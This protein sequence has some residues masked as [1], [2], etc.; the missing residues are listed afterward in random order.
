MAVTPQRMTLA[1]FLELPEVKPALELR[2][3]VVSQK[4]PPSG[5]HSSIQMWFGAQVYNYGEL[6]GLAQAFTEARVI[7]NGDAYVPDVIVFV[8]DR[9][10]VDESGRYPFYFTLPPDL[11]LE[12]VSPGQT[13]SSQLDKCL[14]L[15]EHGVRV[16]LL[17]DPE[18]MAV[19]VL[20]RQAASGPLGWGHG[21]D[22]ADVIPGFE[23]TTD[24]LL[25]RVGPQRT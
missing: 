12:V 22:V 19:H 3:G 10:Q 11:I 24:D 16:A 8:V 5:P 21:I 7:L 2:Q 1:R 4:M 15:I 18:R 20:R 17:V 23:L 6:R 14:E 25:S 9:V 13:V